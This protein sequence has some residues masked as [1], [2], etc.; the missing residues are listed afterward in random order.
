MAVA[1]IR[2]LHVHRLDPD[3]KAAL[4]AETEER[5]DS[6]NDV[7]VGILAARFGIRFAG[8]GRRSPGAAITSGPLNLSIPDA[9]YCKIEAAVAR[10]PKGRR[11]KVCVVEDTFRDYFAA[12]AA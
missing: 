11:S 10:Q 4:V 5:E 8:S 1:E 2:K 6:L 7:A 12:T 9:L 3:L